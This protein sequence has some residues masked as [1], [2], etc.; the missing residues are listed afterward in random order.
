MTNLQ[1][2]L[3]LRI[4]AALVHF[5]ISLSVAFCAA[6]LI[7]L[8]WYPSP[9]QAAVGANKLFWLILTVDVILGPLLTL[10]V[11][12][13]RKKSLKFDLAV[14]AFVQLAALTYGMQTMYYGKPAYVALNENRFFLARVNEI[15]PGWYTRK[16]THASF[17]SSDKFF[18]PKFAAVKW[19]TDI[20]ARNDLMFSNSSARVDHYIPI[21]Q[22]AD[23]IRQV[24][25]PFADLNKLNKGRDQELAATQARWQAQGVKELGFVPLR[26]EQ[27]DMAVLVDRQAG[28]VLEIAR[29]AP[30]E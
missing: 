2:T 10:V 13:P 21:E 22:A 30:W 9:L 29:F 3:K 4:R 19:P 20:E 7:F 25:K 8:A 23:Q 6:A 14:I 15:E 18:A 26:A 16:A 11:F 24:S 27:E 12:N 17:Q 28:K 5:G 1:Q